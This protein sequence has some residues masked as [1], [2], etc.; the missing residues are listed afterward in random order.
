[1]DEFKLFLKEEPVVSANGFDG[2]EGEERDK[3]DPQISGLQA[4]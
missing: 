2:D 1:M 3:D 4:K